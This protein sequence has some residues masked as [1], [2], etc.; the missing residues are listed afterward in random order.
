MQTLLEDVRYAL[1]G[2]RRSPGFTAMAVIALAL[3]IGA[4]TAIFSVVNAVL[5][6]P[7]PYHDSGRLVVVDERHLTGSEVG[8]VSPANF[9]DWREQNRVF[10]PVDEL[11]SLC[12]ASASSA[13]SSQ[14]SDC[15][16]TEHGAVAP[17]SSFGDAIALT[18]PHYPVS[19][20]VR[21]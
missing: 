6:R 18:S 5:L 2:L 21:G 19:G 15:R 12:P 3:G 11:R 1:R 20:D 9:L 16:A 14:E 4:N 10:D 8:N 17:P 13:T 7:L